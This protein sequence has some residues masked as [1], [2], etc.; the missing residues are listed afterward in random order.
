MDRS[1]NNNKSRRDMSPV[2]EK[3][4]DGSGPHLHAGFKDPFEFE[5]E[6]TL[7]D[8]G[9]YLS[10][11]GTTLKNKGR[12]RPLEL[13][14]VKPDRP[15]NPYTAEK[16]HVNP[17]TGEPTSKL[18]AFVENNV[19]SFFK[20]KTP[21]LGKVVVRVVASSDKEV[22]FG[23]N[24][25]TMEKFIDSNEMSDYMPYRKKIIFAFQNIGGAEVCFFGMSVE[26]YGSNCAPQNARRVYLSMVDSVKYLQPA[27]Y[28][29]AVYQQ[30]VINYLAYVKSL[31]YTLFHFYSC[32]SM[33]G[34]DYVFHGKPPNQKMPDQQRLREWY[35]ALLNKAVTQGVVEDW[36]NSNTKDPNFF[37]ASLQSAASTD[38]IIDPDEHIDGGFMV[39]ID[40]F[41][42]FVENSGNN[43]RTLAS[44]QVTTQEFLRKLHAIKK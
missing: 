23:S 6:D 32:P 37:V 24:P 33:E 19:N 1:I 31:G 30:I 40:D 13:E 7:E 25:Y 12:K 11:I 35:E 17:D 5:D 28:Q 20:G 2:S 29:T 34:F 16:L 41:L 14:S 10:T 15:E 43:F 8:S 38:G 3:T 22:N 26:E 18:A 36:A 21:E 27:Q 9:P 42:A 4:R 44:A 39:E